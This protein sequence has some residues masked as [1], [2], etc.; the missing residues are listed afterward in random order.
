MAID[1][2]SYKSA[3]NR[4]Y[5]AIFHAMRSVLAFDDIDMKHHSGIISEFRRLYIKTNVLIQSS[6]LLSLCFLTF[7]QIVIMMISL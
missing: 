7:V 3:A 1:A 4:S 2:K 6:H 5:Y